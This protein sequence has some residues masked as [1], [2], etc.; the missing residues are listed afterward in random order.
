MLLG[1]G[2]FNVVEGVIDHHILSI[3]HVRSGE[4]QTPWDIGFLVFGALLVIIGWLVRRGAA[5][6]DVCDSDDRGR[7]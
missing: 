2:M 5:P 7:P 1:W 4:F 3:H 6:L